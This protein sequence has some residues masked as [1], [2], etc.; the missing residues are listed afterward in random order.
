M[1]TST[2]LRVAL[3]LV[4]T[5]T[6]PGFASGTRV[7][8]LSDLGSPPLGFASTEIRRALDLRGFKAEAAGYAGRNDAERNPKIVLVALTD[9]AGRRIAESEGVAPAKPMA[10]QAF[11][12]RKGKTPGCW[13]IVGADATGAMYGGLEIAEILRL[14]GSLDAIRETSQAPAIARRG[15]KFNIPLDART[16][17]YADAGDSAQQN[18]AEMWSI[19][20][21]REFLDEMARHRYNVLTLWSLHP[22]PSMVKVPEYPKVALDDVMR[23]IARFDTTYSLTGSDM[24]RRETLANL[25]TVRKMTIDQKIAFWRDVMQYAHDR[26]IEV[27][28]FTWNIFVWGT[29]GKY[30]ITASQTN[31]TTIDYFRKS[32]RQMFLTYPHLAGMGITAGENMEGR[33]DEF[34]KEKWLW[35]TYGEGIRDV[36]RLQPDRPIRLIHRFHQTSAKEILDQWKEF[37]GTLDLSFKHAQAHMYASTSPPFAKKTLAE[38]PSNLRTW[39]TIRNDDLYYFRWGDPAFARAYLRNLPGPEKLAGFYMGPDGYTWGREFV[40]TEPETPRQ[41]VIRRQWYSFMLWGRLS[42]D[43]G[44]PDERFEKVLGQRF[45]EVP[46][47]SLFQ[48]TQRASQVIPLVTRFHWEDFDFQWYPEACTSHPKYKGFHTVVHF[49]EG[50]AMPGSGLVNIAAYRDRILAGQPLGGRTPPEVAAELQGHARA[51]LE[52]LSKFGRPKDKELRL[53][54]GD[55][56]ATAHLGDYYAE[57]ILGATE[58]AFFVKNRDPRRKEAAVGHLQK[59]LEHWKQYAA[60]ASRQYRPQLLSR[61]GYVDLRA[62]TEMVTNDIERA[63]GWNR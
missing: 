52:K 33:Q 27:Y 13:L 55:L 29:E 21:W 49:M 57:K 4:V 62:M 43:P 28:V 56:E 8:V 42:Y 51:V 46:A 24:V 38:L 18:I 23:T 26:G 12:V 3:L 44:L 31:P 10:A 47:K 17:S 32:I 30:G 40:A 9:A 54:L 2:T 58:L 34:S 39:M 45:P 37:P 6:R 19:D 20:F 53:W 41:L 15:I 22:F 63:K 5:A 25:V 36:K 1:G 14:A 16:P 60:V 7:Q 61:V 48:A 35:K 11:V 50:R 59:A